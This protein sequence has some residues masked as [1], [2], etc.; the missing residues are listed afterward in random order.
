[1]SRI[2]VVAAS[3]VAVA[4]LSAGATGCTPSQQS[5]VGGFLAS[6]ITLILFASVYGDPLPPQPGG[7][8][9]PAPTTPP[10]TPSDA[11]APAR[12]AP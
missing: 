1:M 2:R 9:P 4:T 5:E 6:L 12:V 8:T 11:V 7:T 10:D 3:I